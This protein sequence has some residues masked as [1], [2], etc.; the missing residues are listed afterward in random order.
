MDTDGLRVPTNQMF[1]EVVSQLQ[2]TSE[3]LWMFSIYTSALSGH[4]FSC[5]IL[6]NYVIILLRVWF[7]RLGFSLNL[8][9][10][11]ALI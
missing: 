5:L 7:Y 11:L 6:L 10:D 8:V 1:Q 3:N 2:T 9:L 4:I